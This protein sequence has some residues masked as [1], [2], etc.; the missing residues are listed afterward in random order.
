MRRLLGGAAIAMGACLACLGIHP[1][2]VQEVDAGPG[3]QVSGDADPACFT[4][5]AQP[6]HPGPGCATELAACQADPQCA[7]ALV[8]ATQKNCFA[9]GSLAAIG[10]CG[11]PCITEAGVISFDTPPFKLAVT[12][13]Q[14]VSGPCGVPCHLVVDGGS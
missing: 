3:L 10:V 13:F 8:C 5:L 9:S 6:D 14:C 12:L 2:S 1:V 7:Q 4:C 11:L